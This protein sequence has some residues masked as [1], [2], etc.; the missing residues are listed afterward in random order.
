MPQPDSL[1]EALFAS[2]EAAL[3]LNVIKK[4]NLDARD[5]LFKLNVYQEYTDTYSFEEAPMVKTYLLRTL[6]SGMHYYEDLLQYIRTGE[7]RISINDKVLGLGFPR[8]VMLNTKGKY[9]EAKV[10]GKHESITNNRNDNYSF[11]QLDLPANTIRGT[12]VGVKAQ[13]ASVFEC[14]YSG[15]ILQPFTLLHTDTLYTQRGNANYRYDKRIAGQWV[16]A[17]ENGGLTFKNKIEIPFYSLLLNKNLVT[18]NSQLKSE[19]G[20]QVEVL[21]EGK[22]TKVSVV[23]IKKLLSKSKLGQYKFTYNTSKK[24]FNLEILHQGL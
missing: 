2:A 20:E 7:F 3:W 1:C 19:N 17:L 11:E 16:I 15:V 22:I 12:K 8:Q 23:K 14:P 24:V 21:K 6:E 9:L 5:M 4:Y 13:F 10:Q 18:A